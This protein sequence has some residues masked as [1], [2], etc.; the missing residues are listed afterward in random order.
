[1]LNLIMKTMIVMSTDRSPMEILMKSDHAQPDDEN[2]DV[3]YNG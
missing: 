1:M 3:E 2:N